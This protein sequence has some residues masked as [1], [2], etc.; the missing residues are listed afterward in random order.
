[1]PPKRK[2]LTNQRFGKLTAL[3]RGPNTQNHNRST[4]ICTCDCGNTTIVWAKRLQNSD[5]RSCGCLLLETCLKHG[6]SNETTEYAAW[7]S[8]KERTSNPNHKTYHYYGGRGITVCDAWK[9]SFEVFF[10]DMGRKP[11]PNHSLDRIDND[12]NYEPSN[13]RW[14]TRSEQQNNTRRNKK[15]RV[16]A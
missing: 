1:M 6:Q 2:D 12:G 8:M 13:C 5:T 3:T 14:A 10:H 16:A 9:N 15:N 11:T 7:R 4:W